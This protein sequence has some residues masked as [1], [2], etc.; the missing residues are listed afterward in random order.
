MT[1]R[2]IICSRPQINPSRCQHVMIL[3]DMIDRSIVA[4]HRNVNY[5]KSAAIRKQVFYR[6][7]R[8]IN[9]NYFR[10]VSNIEIIALKL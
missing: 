5:C 9:Y 1:A 2:E 7:I 10:I 3:W 6:V 8:G 4:E